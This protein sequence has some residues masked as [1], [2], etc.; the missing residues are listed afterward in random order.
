MSERDNA[1]FNR[2]DAFIAMANE[3]MENGTEPGEVSASFMYSLARY[4][5]WFSAS[6]WTKS[7]DM[8]DA[9]DETIEFFV[10]EY[11]QMLTMNMDDYIQHFDNYIQSSKA[12]EQKS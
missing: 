2:A 8:A 7:K 11:R 4:T 12:L 9:R 5:A 1:F 3:Q 10:K 6:G